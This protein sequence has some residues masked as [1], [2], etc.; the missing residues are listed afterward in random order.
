VGPRGS[1]KWQ[2]ISWDEALDEVAEA[3]V[4]GIE[5]FGPDSFLLD[6]AHFH[7]GGV[8]YAG[9]YRFNRILGGVSLDWNIMN[10]DI[11]MG[12]H[13]TLGKM[14]M[15]FSADN[16]LDAELII[17]TCA[18]WSY[19]APP[20]YHFITEARYNGTEFVSIAPDYS[21][22]TVHADYH[23][24]IKTGG[25]AAFWLGMC[26]VMIED[27]LIDRPFMK[28]QT[29]LALLRRKDTGKFLRQA[30][31]DG[32]GRDDQFYFWDLK[33]GGMAKAPRGTLAFDGDQALEGDYTATLADGTEVDVEPVFEA[34]KRQLAAEY[35]PAKAA[36]K[37]GV[38]AGLI[39]KL[40]RKMATKRTLTNVGWGGCKIY[41]SDLNERALLLASAL[42]GNWGKPGTGQTAYAMPAD[43]IEMLMVMEKPLHEGGL[44]VMDGMRDAVGFH[45]RC[46]CITTAATTNCTTRK[47]GR[48]QR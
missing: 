21:P 9:V 24:P 3:I 29:D 37:S 14:N 5:E 11:F 25:D 34:V 42:S 26:Q 44:H 19:T 8:A 33:T 48:I 27:D 47:S 40:G 23:V 17:M 1:G 30:D 35:T 31:I 46:F 45:R 12:F 43:H 39:R 32:E 41:H 4:D 22:S 38:D 7:A 10:G 15:A 18:N 2:R 36:K 13:E 6:G 20:L 16:L 28:E